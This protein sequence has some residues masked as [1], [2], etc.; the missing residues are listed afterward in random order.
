MKFGLSRFLKTPALFFTK[1][2]SAIARHSKCV[3]KF[4]CFNLLIQPRG[5][6][7]QTEGFGGLSATTDG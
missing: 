1:T 5:H 4:I 2:V 6:L 7:T 3:S